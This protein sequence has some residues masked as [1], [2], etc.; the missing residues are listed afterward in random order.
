MTAGGVAGGAGLPVAPAA[1]WPQ[2]GVVGGCEL[3]A[4]RWPLGRQG[5]L[6]PQGMDGW[7]QLPLPA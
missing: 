7:M 3:E 5:R 1:W 4:Q 2:T 6:R